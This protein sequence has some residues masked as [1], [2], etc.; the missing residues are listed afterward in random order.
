MIL[1]EIVDG[2]VVSSVIFCLTEATDLTIDFVIDTG[3]N[4]KEIA[5][6]LRPS[7]R[8]IAVRD[9]VISK[10][11]DLPKFLDTHPLHNLYGGEHNWK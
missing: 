1:G 3:F 2:R 10:P 4:C 6:V 7:G 9:H 11:E 8:F 5:R